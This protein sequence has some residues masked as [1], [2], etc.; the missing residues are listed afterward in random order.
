MKNNFLTSMLHKMENQ[1]TSTSFNRVDQDKQR[2]NTSCKNTFTAKISSFPLFCIFLLLLILPLVNCS[3][4]SSLEGHHSRIIGFPFFSYQENRK[5]GS[6]EEPSENIPVYDNEDIED[7]K[8]QS[9]QRRLLQL[10]ANELA[11]EDDPTGTIYGQ[12]FRG[13]KRTKGGDFGQLTIN[14]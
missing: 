6:F 4:E 7:K 14:N 2:K 12:T 11:E 8:T 5:G 3:L 9:R 13:A 10:V 1:Q